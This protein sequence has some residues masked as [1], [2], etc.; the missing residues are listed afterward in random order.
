MLSKLNRVIGTIGINRSSLK[1]SEFQSNQL[2]RQSLS[3]WRL[4]LGGF[5]LFTLLTITAY[6]GEDT[7]QRYMQSKQS[8]LAIE[9]VEMEYYLP[10]SPNQ[11]LQNMEKLYQGVLTALNIELAFRSKIVMS[12]AQEQMLFNGIPLTFVY[13]VQIEKPGLL[14]ASKRYMQEI[15]YQ[16]YY[17]GLSKQFVVRNLEQGKQHSYPTLSLAILS[18][19]TP[20]DIEFYIED[21]T[22]I[23]LQDYVGRAKLWLDIEALPTPLRI[24]AYLS[25]HWWLNSQWFKWEF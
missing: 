5:L 2:L 15:H 18:I 4:I 20:T 9:Q 25:S 8:S 12:D 16:L 22:G 17:H 10:K 24:P 13:E 7:V 19:S 1:S 6:A 21:V 11:R 14:W 23:S 3:A